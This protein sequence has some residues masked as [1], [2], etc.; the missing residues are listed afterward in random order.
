M[1]KPS[2][3]RNGEKHSSDILEKEDPEHHIAVDSFDYQKIE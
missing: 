2:L 3:L 1:H